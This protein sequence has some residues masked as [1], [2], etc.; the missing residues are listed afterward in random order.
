LTAVAQHL[1]LCKQPDQDLHD[2]AYNRFIYD[3]VIPN[4]HSDPGVVADGLLDFVPMYGNAAAGSCLRA[5][6]MA[7]C[8]A[9]YAGRFKSAEARLQSSEHC[10]RAL[11]LMQAAI[12]DPMEAKSDETLL[13][14]YLL[15]IWEVRRLLLSYM[16]YILTGRTIRT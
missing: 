9:N 4:A 1:S 16:K 8:C 3:F 2:L 12:K 15:G 11:K 14:V 13:T 5:A 6:T 7:V 10:G